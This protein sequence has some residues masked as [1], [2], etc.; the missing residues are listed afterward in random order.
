MPLRCRCRAQQH[1]SKHRR[2]SMRQPINH[3]VRD[4]SS[5]KDTPSLTFCFTLCYC[6]WKCTNLLH[7]EHHFAFDTTILCMQ[8]FEDVVSFSTG[9]A[10]WNLGICSNEFLCIK[11]GGKLVHFKPRKP[12]G[13]E[14]CGPGVDYPSSDREKP[15]Q[16]PLFCQMTTTHR[17]FTVNVGIKQQ[18]KNVVIHKEFQVCVPATLCDSTSIQ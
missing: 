15:Q 14:C 7:H 9:K 11:K 5:A 2:L 10:V 18:N 4:T 1:C 16:N 13:D 17:H 8:C 12:L 6:L 3:I